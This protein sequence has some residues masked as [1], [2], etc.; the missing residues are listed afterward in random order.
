MLIKDIKIKFFFCLDWKQKWNSI[1]SG[2]CDL[3]FAVLPSEFYHHHRLWGATERSMF[4]EEWK[5]SPNIMFY[6]LGHL[7]FRQLTLSLISCLCPIIHAMRLSLFKFCKGNHKQ[8]AT[9][10]WG[11]KIVRQGGV[12][13]CKIIKLQRKSDY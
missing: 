10:T 3:C 13:S 1:G 5:S 12:L 6:G 7:F 4:G 11:G 9:P 8:L 2:H